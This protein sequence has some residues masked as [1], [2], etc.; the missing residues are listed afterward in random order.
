MPTNLYGPND[1][2][3][4][5]KSHVLPALLRKTHLLKLAAAGDRAAIADDEA[6]FGQIPDEFRK[7][8]VGVGSGRAGLVVWGTGSPKREFLYVDD[9]ADACVFLME[10]GVGEGMYN[11][12][13]GTDLSIGELAE[14]VQDVVGYRGATTFDRSKPDGTPRKILDVSLLTKRGWRAQTGLEAGI[15][16]AYQDYLSRM[17]IWRRE[18]SGMNAED[19]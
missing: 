2:Y 8:L 13:T 6:C 16:L 12:G 17:A 15:R 5:E 14:L 19:R 4:L 1:N 7:F 11:V 18:L 10:K 9:M 3:D